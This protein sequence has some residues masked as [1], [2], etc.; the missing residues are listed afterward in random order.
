MGSKVH[1]HMQVSDLTK[2]RAFYERFWR[3]R[4]PCRR[5]GRTV[6]QWSRRPGVALHARAAHS[7]A[8]RVS[9]AAVAARCSISR[10]SALSFR[11]SPNAGGK[12]VKDSGPVLRLRS[13]AQTFVSF[14]D[15][16]L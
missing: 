2:S 5:L 4:P 1:V 6:C 12:A 16:S 9:E 7:V 15:W 13:G 10:T 14:P 3:A 8:C 11:G